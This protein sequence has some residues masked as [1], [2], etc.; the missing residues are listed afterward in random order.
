ML[1]TLQSWIFYP[2][3]FF[4]I[5]IPKG[6][7]EKSMKFNKSLFAKS[8]FENTTLNQNQLIDYLIGYMSFNQLKKLYNQIE[9]TNKITLF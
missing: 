9:K 4:K 5:I 2:G 1:S 8:L 6:K 3:F 7:L